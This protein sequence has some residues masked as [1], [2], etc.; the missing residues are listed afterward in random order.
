MKIKK[1]ISSAPLWCC[2]ATGLFFTACEK[3]IIDESTEE[4]V[5]VKSDQTAN[6]VLRMS[7]FEQ[8]GSSTRTATDIR[9]LCSR[10][11]VA[12]FSEESKQLSLTQKAEDEDFGT[13]AFRV[14][15]GTYRLVVIA[16][17]GEGNATISST[18]KVTFQNNKVTDTFYYSDDIVVTSEKQ[19]Y[20]LSLIRAVAK[21]KLTLSDETTPEGV[22]KFKFYYTGGSSTFSP[23][24]GFG[25]VNSKQ[26]E[27]REVN[28]KG[29]YE[30][31]TCPHTQ[32]DVLTK[33]TVTALDANDNTIKE[34]VFEDIP[35][36]RNQITE[37]NGSFFDEMNGS[38][39]NGSFVMTADPEWEA[40]NTFS[41]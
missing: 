14:A 36:V 3:P 15:E 5:I 29:V 8:M 37:Y 22:T 38:T 34:R 27:I 7:E 10:I 26:T 39:G 12:L 41:F 24:T 13:I 28:E 31:Y 21:F 20:N 17:N 33:L 23:A 6:V 9:Q 25:C 30:I 16:H 1:I 19:E 4:S 2:M 11:S 35:I 18:E 32:E 40:T